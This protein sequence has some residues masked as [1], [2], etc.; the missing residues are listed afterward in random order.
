LKIQL[1]MQTAR[2]I[3]KLSS[4][5]LL[6]IGLA[7]PGAADSVWEHNGSTLQLREEGTLRS[8]R[9]SNPRAEL[10][11]AGVE[12]G[13]V[14]FEGKKI[15]DR[16]SGTAYRFSRGCG[17]V[18]YEVKG[19]VSPSVG[20][21]TLSGRA[22]RRNSKCEVVG[23]FTD[24][25]VFRRRGAVEQRPAAAALDKKL[26]AA[27]QPRK[28]KREITPSD[29]SEDG[30]ISTQPNTPPPTSKAQATLPYPVMGCKSRGTF[31]Q[32]VEMFRR[33][34]PASEAKVVA[35][36]MRTKDCAAL[37]DGPVDIDQADD[38]YL[39]V[40]PIGHVNCYWTLRASVR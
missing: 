2:I 39:C 24:Q 25:L 34:D 18:G 26:T 5:S 10:K 28:Q 16:F 38:S 40:R 9:Y 20:A 30:K 19:A 21:L 7:V 8:F 31:D 12:D 14:L 35:Q 11:K 1:K 3:T 29:G 6:L 33:A 22:P 37:K 27:A 13:T 4:C 36:G 17:A 23:H 15:G 32:W